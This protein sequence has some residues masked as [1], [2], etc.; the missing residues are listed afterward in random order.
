VMCEAVRAS[1]DVAGGCALLFGVGH[2]CTSCRLPHRESLRSAVVAAASLQPSA[3]CA[4]VR[5]HRYRATLMTADMRLFALR[6]VI[7]T[8]PLFGKSAVVVLLCSR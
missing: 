7:I 1:S 3:P 5:H 2:R 8:A 4:A 6:Y